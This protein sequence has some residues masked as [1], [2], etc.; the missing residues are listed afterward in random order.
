M[1]G[2]DRCWFAA[3]RLSNR[4][5]KRT[6]TE[7]LLADP[8]L[9]Q[10]RKRRFDKLQVRCLAFCCLSCQLQHSVL[11]P[12]DLVLAACLLVSV[13]APGKGHFAA[14]K[15]PCSFELCFSSMLGVLMRVV[16][17]KAL[18]CAEDNL[19]QCQYMSEHSACM[20]QDEKAYWAGKRGRKT[21]LPRGKKTT[22]SKKH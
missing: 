7:E 22:R 15:S 6:I 4:E 21:D 18:L 20:V 17:A 16:S 19:T 9:S 11:Q 13:N 3:G 8:D 2:R 1:K 12:A 14:A 10:A 5:R